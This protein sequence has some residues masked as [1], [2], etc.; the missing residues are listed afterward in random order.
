MAKSEEKVNND[1]VRLKKRFIN[2][3]QVMS[4]HANEAT[5]T[6]TNNEFFL[7]FYRIEPPL[8][9]NEGDKKALKEANDIDAVAVAK[10]VLS[11]SFAR[12]VGKVFEDQLDKFEDSIGGS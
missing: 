7:T 8:V 11:P 3:E 10:I 9:L 5:L 6:H 1:F 12:A 4:I 2:P